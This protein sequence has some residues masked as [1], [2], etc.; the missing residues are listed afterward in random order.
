M[1]AEFFL[2]TNIFVYSFD[3]SAPK[4]REWS[5]EGAGKLARD[6]LIRTYP[7]QHN[8]LSN[9]MFKAPEHCAACHKQPQPRGRGAKPGQRRSIPCSKCALRHIAM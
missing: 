3:D 5:E 9:R 2:D 1:P 8:L 7:D 6:F 4:K